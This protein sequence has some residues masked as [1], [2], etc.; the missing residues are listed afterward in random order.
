MFYLKYSVISIWY[1]VISIW[2]LVSGIKK[3]NNFT[4][5]TFYTEISC[6]SGASIVPK[7]FSFQF[8]HPYFFANMKISNG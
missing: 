4:L 2:Y 8:F 3:Y 5:I 1:S 7:S 6:V